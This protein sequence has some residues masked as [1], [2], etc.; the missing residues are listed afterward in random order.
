MV[1]I[2]NPYPSQYL[3]ITEWDLIGIP[4]LL[5]EMNKTGIEHKINEDELQKSKYTTRFQNF[6]LPE[7]FWN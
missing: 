7:S 2:T 5:Y 3:P 4:N 6:H 1:E